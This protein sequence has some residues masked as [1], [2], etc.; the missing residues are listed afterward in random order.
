MYIIVTQKKEERK[1]FTK[2]HVILEG[3]IICMVYQA[4]PSLVPKLRLAFHGLQ[5]SPR[6]VQ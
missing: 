2:I 1:F 4:R 5:I 6:V 3:V